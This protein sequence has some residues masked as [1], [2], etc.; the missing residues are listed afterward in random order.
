MIC[1]AELTNK[2][3][4]LIFKDQFIGLVDCLLWDV[5]VIFDDEIDLSTINTTVIVDVIEV[6]LHRR[7]YLVVARRSNTGLWNGNAELD[8]R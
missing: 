2:C 5:F 6:S 4:D 1:G 8:L 3:E 7:S